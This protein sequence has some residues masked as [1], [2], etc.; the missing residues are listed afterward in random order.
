MIHFKMYLAGNLR[1]ITVYRGFYRI[2]YIFAREY[3]RRNQGPFL[4]DPKA[5]CLRF[6]SE[7]PESVFEQD[8]I[9][10]VQFMFGQALLAY[11]LTIP[12]T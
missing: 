8:D 3:Y 4:F 1:T 5:Q 2:I 7:L 6:M 10:M 11:N 9:G 12:Q